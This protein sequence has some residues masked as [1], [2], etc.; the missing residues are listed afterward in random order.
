MPAIRGVE[1]LPEKTLPEENWPE[2][3]WSMST[4]ALALLVFV[5]VATCTFWIASGL[6][7]H[8]SPWARDVCGLSRELCD[9]PLW[10]AIATAATGLLYLVLRGLQL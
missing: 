1:G 6:Y 3:N 5:A 2:E 7:G 10:G 4:L 8:G 9:H